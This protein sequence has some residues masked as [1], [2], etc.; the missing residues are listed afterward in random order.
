MPSRAVRR[1]KNKENVE[2]KKTLPAER[3]RRHPLLYAGSLA[4]L[5]IIVVAFVGGPLAGRLGSGG[6]LIFGSYGGKEISYVQGNYLARQVDILSDQ[7]QDNT[8]QNYEWQ[9]YQ[10]W[11]G[12]YDRA[13]IR[14]AILQKADKAGVYISDNAIDALLL[15]TGPYMENGVFSETRYRNTS[16]SERFR[17]RQLYREEMTH[18]LYNADV[19]HI[20]FFSTDGAE[21]IK[22]M[23]ADERSFYY[24]IFSYKEYP[25]SKVVA[26]AEENAS[27]FRKIKMSRITIKST[28]DE[29]VAVRQ[30]ILDGIATFENQAHL[31]LLPLDPLHQL[32]EL[33]L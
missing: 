15:T 21:F 17:Y 1:R 23:A 6:P 24:A 33:D 10:V 7:L 4:L 5:V 13:V 12:A 25:V 22:K 32:D 19:L 14:T 20:G 8:S 26:Y 16:N 18:Q 9:A 27:N 31:Q 30:Q 11:K 2:I 28:V 29:A 3:R